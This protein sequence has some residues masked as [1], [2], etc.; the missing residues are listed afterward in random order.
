MYLLSSLLLLTGVLYS[1][2]SVCQE[3]LTASSFSTIPSHL[4]PATAHVLGPWLP[5]F[6]TTPA[7]RPLVPGPPPG[8]FR[9]F[10]PVRVSGRVSQP[11]QPVLSKEEAS[12][13][14]HVE[15]VMQ[16]PSH[17]QETYY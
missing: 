12:I 3:R 5:T 14:A 4:P 6:G 15:R 10:I 16:F 17:L 9:S 7:S 8:P 1:K 13:V 2:E 11:T